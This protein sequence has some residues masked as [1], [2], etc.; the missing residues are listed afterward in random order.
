VS[1]HL[2]RGDS[3]LNMYGEGKLDVNSDWYKYFLDAKKHFYNKKVKFFV[4]TG[5][6]RLGDGIEDDYTWCKNNLIGDEY[7]FFDYSKSTINDF[8]LMYLCD[9]HILS[10]ISTLSWWVGFLNKKKN[11]K[12]IIAPK[13]YYFLKK[14]M[15]DGF[16]PNNFILI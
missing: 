16:Y 15:E 14:E 2:R 6:S 1:L 9:H 11:N 7:V 13:K 5:G 12:L 4:F 10:P 8:V 3:D